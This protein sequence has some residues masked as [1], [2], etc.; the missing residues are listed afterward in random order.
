MARE[1]EERKERFGRTGKKEEGKADGFPRTKIMVE[2]ND[3]S[4]KRK[5]KWKF[6]QEEGE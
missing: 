5:G 6:M 4:D 1:E 2:E 3:N